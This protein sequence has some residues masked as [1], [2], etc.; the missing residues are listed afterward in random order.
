M[1]GG[2]VIKMETGKQG[3]KV[4]L[5]NNPEFRKLGTSDKA[6]TLRSR[7]WTPFGTMCL[8]AAIGPSS[9]SPIRLPSP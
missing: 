2:E 7:R 6:V 3:E 5:L 9:A 1:T 4:Q 8:A